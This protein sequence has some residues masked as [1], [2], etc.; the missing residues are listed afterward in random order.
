MNTSSLV[1]RN[2]LCAVANLLNDSGSSNMIPVANV[3]NHILSLL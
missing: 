3:L 1:S 2:L